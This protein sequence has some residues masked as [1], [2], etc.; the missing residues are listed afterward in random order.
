MWVRNQGFFD[1]L[2]FSIH[3]MVSLKWPALGGDYRE[4]YRDWQKKKSAKH[5]PMGHWLWTGA[6][7]LALALA[8]LILYYHFA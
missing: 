1:A 3:R 7:Y 2:T 6:V 5:A 8:A 4:K